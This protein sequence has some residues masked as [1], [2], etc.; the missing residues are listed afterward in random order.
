MSTAVLLESGQLK[1]L[2]TALALIQVN[3]TENQMRGQTVWTRQLFLYQDIFT[4]KQ[5]IIH[6]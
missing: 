5:I 1:Q 3:E 6:I 4:A 2:N